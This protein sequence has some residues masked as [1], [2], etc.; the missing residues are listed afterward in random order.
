[1]RLEPLG[2]DSGVLSWGGNQAF[3]TG[4]ALGS[5]I[6]RRTTSPNGPH[7]LHPHCSGRALQLLSYKQPPKPARTASKPGRPEPIFGG[8]GLP[9]GAGS[10]DAQPHPTDLIFRTPHCS[11]RAL[12]LLSDKQPTKPAKPASKIGRPEAV[13]RGTCRRTRLDSDHFCASF[14]SI[15]VIK[16]LGFGLIST[17]AFRWCAGLVLNRKKQIFINF[18]TPEGRAQK[19]GRAVAKSPE[20][21]CCRPAGSAHLATGA[22]RT[23]LGS[24]L[25]SAMAGWAPPA[26]QV[27]FWSTTRPFSSN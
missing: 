7:I 15:W 26:V 1:M 8:R 23:A 2:P 11:G 22:G 18:L 20:S 3:S 16:D 27:L 17:R 4:S 24:W 13:F 10:L 21:S 14:K 19:Q 9:W 6:S 25:A 5:A 12:Q